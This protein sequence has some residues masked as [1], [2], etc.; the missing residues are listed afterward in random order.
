MM[1]CV[2][3]RQVGANEAA[4]RLLRHKLYSK[5]RPMRFA[6]LEPAR[7]ARHLLVSN[8]NY[9]NSLHLCYKALLFFCENIRLK[10]LMNVL[11]LP[12][13]VSYITLI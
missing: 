11:N 2:K 7:K 13:L 1:K 4:D 6:D 10:M 3:S 12:V 5:S 9:C 8:D